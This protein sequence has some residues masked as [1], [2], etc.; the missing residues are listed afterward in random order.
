MQN[1]N[2][3]R[4]C[5]FLLFLFCFCRGALQTNCKSRVTCE[6]EYSIILNIQIEINVE[7]LVATCQ[8]GNIIIPFVKQVRFPLKHLNEYSTKRRS[9]QRKFNLQRRVNGTREFILVVLEGAENSRPS[10]NR[11][12]QIIIILFINYFA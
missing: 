5:T 6:S 10:T 1:Q 8:F 3:Q 12:F 2:R 9:H 7:Y 4:K 11:M